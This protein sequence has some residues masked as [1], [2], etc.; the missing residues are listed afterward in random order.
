M[1]SIES[2]G[3]EKTYNK[4]AQ[5]QLILYL[6]DVSTISK[7]NI[8]LFLE[9]VQATKKNYPAA[10]FLVVLNKTDILHSNEVL[11]FLSKLK[12]LSISAKTGAGIE[13]T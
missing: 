9:E 7:N 11:T 13:T 3:I 5:S 12:P 1:D 6:L 10:K 8:E 4:M 2:I